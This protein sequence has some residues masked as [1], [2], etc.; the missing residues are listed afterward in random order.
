[1]AITAGDDILASDFIDASSGTTHSGKGVKL[2]ADGKLDPSF[3]HFGGDGSDGALSISSGTTTIDC[4]NARVV[5]KNYTSISITSTGKLAFSN[6]H[7]NGTIVI[8][9]SQGDVTLTASTAPMIDM[10]AMGATGGSSPTCNN[11]GGSQGGGSGTVGRGSLIKT[12]AGSGGNGTSSSTAGAASSAIAFPSVEETIL[13]YYHAFVG[14]GGG[15]GACY[16]GSVGASGSVGGE[17]GR[18]GGC[19]IIEC[20]GAW[21]FTTAS[22]ISVAGEDGADGTTD[23]TS[24]RQGAGGGGGAGGFFLA[25]VKSITSDI[26]TITISGGTG[27]NRDGGNNA[28]TISG[29]AGGGSA[30]NAGSNGTSSS[31]AG[32]KTGGDGADGFSLVANINE[33][34]FI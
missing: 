25:L 5:V 1:M 9:K 17:G 21:D 34:S 28:N 11:S 24:N 6:P 29:G 16:S 30:G 8:L 22:G 26:G 27:G 10:S 20:G 12:E 32:A 18:G 4:A 31:T 15:A 13:R 7:A 3:F 33:V 2:S 14:A 19:L 23:D